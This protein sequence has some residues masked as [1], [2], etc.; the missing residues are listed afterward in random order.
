MGWGSTRVHPGTLR[1]WALLLW[2]PEAS[3]VRTGSTRPSLSGRE[4]SWN[5]QSVPTWQPFSLPP[6]AAPATRKSLLNVAQ[7]QQSQIPSLHT[8][9]R[10]RGRQMQ[11]PLQKA[12]T[13]RQPVRGPFEAD[14]YPRS[15]TRESMA[16][17]QT[18]EL[19]RPEG[20]GKPA[21]VPHRKGL[22]GDR[23]GHPA[24]AHRSAQ[25]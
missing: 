4:R 18:P 25:F 13:E 2:S 11:T 14:T 6:P 20:Q 19:E 16:E 1:S 8:G 10:E 22:L 3:G 12:A 24:T 5:P 17:F 7:S 23:Q 9:V 21:R 15:A